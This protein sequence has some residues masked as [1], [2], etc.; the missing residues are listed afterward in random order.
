[1][2]VKSLHHAAG[3]SQKGTNDSVRVHIKVVRK[4]N[5]RR[6]G[7]PI[8]RFGT[9]AGHVPE[10]AG[11]IAENAPRRGL[12][13]KLPKET[14]RDGR[15]RIDN[16]ESFENFG[17]TTFFPASSR[18]I[19][20]M[21]GGSEENPSAA[22]PRRPSRPH[23]AVRRPRDRSA[24]HRPAVT[25]CTKGYLIVTRTAKRREIE[26]VRERGTEPP[27]PA[28]GERRRTEGEKRWKCNYRRGDY[29]WF[30]GRIVNIFLPFFSRLH[31]SFQ[32][33]NSSRLPGALPSKTTELPFP[34]TPLVT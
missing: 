17:D 33:G 28:A 30:S 3:Q 13:E 25:N 7:L 21:H 19:D 12:R 6:S 4:R 29:K 26:W 11:R 23:F 14:K 10:A 5:F 16:L 24:T 34:E 9:G 15:N 18:D 20:V 32:A 31:S 2:Q 27:R 1:M 22:A 8:P